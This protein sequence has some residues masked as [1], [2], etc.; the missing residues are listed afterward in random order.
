MELE[1]TRARLSSSRRGSGHRDSLGRSSAT[2][3]SRPRHP[4]TARPWSRARAHEVP[5]RGE[6]PRPLA[7]GD[8]GPGCGEDPRPRPSSRPRR[9]PP[10]SAGSSSRTAPAAAA[11]GPERVHCPGR[12]RRLGIDPGPGGPAPLPRA[13]GSSRSGAGCRRRGL[14]WRPPRRPKAG[15]VARERPPRP[16]GLSQRPMA[17]R[18]ERRFRRRLGNRPGRRRRRRLQLQ[19][20]LQLRLHERTERRSRGRTSR[21]TQP[22]VQPRAQQRTGQGPQALGGRSARSGSSPRPKDAIHGPWL[23]P[24]PDQSS[25][26]PSCRS[27]T[28]LRSSAPSTPPAKPPIPFAASTL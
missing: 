25:R 11:R 2:R 19:L 6:P 13:W 20:Q 3:G 27:I 24:D 4:G 23:H 1:W 15:R 18:F 14:R 17:G 10:R 8:R 28:D 5:L 12:G 16:S 26:A 7:Q 22:L 21:R 9:A